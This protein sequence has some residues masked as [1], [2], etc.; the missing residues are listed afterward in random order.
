MNEVKQPKKPLIYYYVI[1]MALVVL[2]NLL[3]MPSLMEMR[4]EQVDYG[5]FMSM[6]EEKNI[7]LVE[8]QSNQIVFTDKEE[9]QVYKTGIVDD[10]GRTERLYAAGAT[11]SGEIIEE[12]SVLASLLGWILPLVLFIAIGQFMSRKLMERMGGPN[13]MSF[14]MGKSNAKVY[15]K[16]SNGISFADVEGVDEA[17]ESLAEIVDYLHDPEKYTE[18]GATMPKGV[19]LVGPPGTGKTMLAKAV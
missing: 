4:V 5:T 3:V 1:A 8:I 10:P 13:A 16:S 15:V 14:S 17:E 12:T 11:F 2:F 19:L 7:G 6:T 18:I 9:T